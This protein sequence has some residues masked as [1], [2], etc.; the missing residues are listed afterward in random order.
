MACSL[1]GHQA[2]ICTNAEILS[3]RNKFQ[4]NL[5]QNS[6]IFIPENAFENVISEITAILSQPQYVKKIYFKIYLP[7][8]STFNV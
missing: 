3:L 2:I 1:D 6:Y 5:D 4:W 7:C 8:C